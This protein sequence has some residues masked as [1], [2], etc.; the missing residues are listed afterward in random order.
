MENFDTAV[1]ATETALNSAGSAERENARYMES[2]E[3]HIQ[4]V[5]K[6]FSD[7]VLGDGGL[8]DLA[9][10]LLDAGTAILNFLNTPLGDL[11]VKI[12]LLVVAMTAL[13]AVIN[14]AFIAGL[15]ATAT[16]LVTT[17]ANCGGF[18]GTL[19]NIVSA[20]V[21]T[22]T[23]TY[24]TS[25]ALGALS[26]TLAELGINP[27]VLGITALIA[28]IYGAVK[29]YKKWENGIKD[30]SDALKSME[31]EISTSTS[32]I[33]Q[34]E[35]KLQELEDSKV[36]LTNP[37]D[38]RNLELEERSLERQ[39]AL[40]KQLLETKQ[41]EA[42]AE[43]E[44]M[45]KKTG[46]GTSA[47][48]T[49]KG[50][51]S[52]EE[53]GTVTVG[54]TAEEQLTKQIEGLKQLNGQIVLTNASLDS[55]KARLDALGV[56]E[57]E[58]T[59]TETQLREGRFANNEQVIQ[60]ILNYQN[61]LATLEGLNNTYNEVNGSAAENAQVL[62]QAAEAGVDNADSLNNL[63]D[64]YID[65]TDTAD[66]AS[67]A[68]E[69]TGEASEDQISAVEKLA[70]KYNVATDAIWDL[71][72]ANEQYASGEIDFTTALGEAEAQLE[73]NTQETQS[74]ADAYKEMLSDLENI[75]KAYETLSAAVEDYNA[76]GVM[77]M[78]NAMA[79]LQ[80]EPE[81]LALLQAE[82]G[83]LR[84]NKSA[85]DALIDA[86]IDEAQATLLAKTEEQAWAIVVADSANTTA[87]AGNA[88]ATAAGKTVTAA[89]DINAAGNTMLTA[90]EKF[91]EA[92][93]AITNGGGMYS[94]L[95]SD[96]TNALLELK[97]SAKS[98]YMALEQTRAGLHHV[99][100][101]ATSAGN[102][103][104]RAA[105]K[106]GSAIKSTT[107]LVREY[108]IKQMD[109]YI[110]KIEAKIAK[111]EKKLDKWEA[112]LEKVQDKYEKLIE[113]NQGWLD[114]LTSN[115]DI[116]ERF[117]STG[118]DALDEL[119]KKLKKK[120]KEYDD[121]VNKI[122]EEIDARKELIEGID[123]EID[124]I[125][126]RQKSIKEYYD[127]QIDALEKANEELEKQIKLE[128]LLDALNKAKSTKVKT[129]V[130]G[131]GFVYTT[132]SEKVSQATKNLQEYQ[133]SEKQKEEKTN[134]EKQRDAEIE[135]L[136]VQKNALE[137]QK[138][139]YELQNKLAEK[140][141]TQLEKEFD[142]QKKLLDY[143][144]QLLYE[145]IYD[146][147][148][149]F[150]NT[151]TE[152]TNKIN[153]KIKKI[154]D[155]IDVQNVKLDTANN[156][157]TK[158]KEKT[159]KQLDGLT[160]QQKQQGDN[161]ISKLVTIIEKMGA[162]KEQEQRTATDKITNYSGKKE[163][164]EKVTW[165]QEKA[166]YDWAAQN[167]PTATEIENM[168]NVYLNGT[169][170]SSTK[171]EST[172][173]SKVATTTTKTKTTTT[174]SKS[175]GTAKS[176][177]KAKGDRY[178]DEDG[179]YLLGDNPNQNELAIG[180]R[181]NGAVGINLSKGSG[182]VP[183]TLTSAL[184]D[185]AEEYKRGNSNAVLNGNTNNNNSTS[186]SI[187]NI[188]LPNVENGESFVDY[189]QNFSLDMT[190]AAYSRV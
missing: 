25:G 48:N 137:Q 1:N 5:R 148:D 156:Q 16:T 110:D 165:E 26:A 177:K 138:K 109:K 168:I 35:N 113:R 22:A 133:R 127:E 44:K 158:Y 155:K 80:L 13:N 15:Q 182:V 7:L 136:E 6:A 149:Q 8:T 46:T 174:G 86:K 47:G 49:W 160:K 57:Q 163:T 126:K 169:S 66:D 162:K 170:S 181:L 166:K 78:E 151:L 65:V 95:S 94:G 124:A 103:A 21:V 115:F 50:Y 85:L 97:N 30:A 75:S 161:I 128:E 27:V 81:Y 100:T 116:V 60:D 188:S 87:S 105:K 117:V 153:A 11:T 34:L 12:G 99:G 55:Y 73:A 74:A 175:S 36:D 63:V 125:E 179:F 146:Q 132:D 45:L 114:T 172:G 159:E 31:D 89:N 77:T 39:I 152:K 106:T 82:D 14:S 150:K 111:L 19:E 190:Q 183:H 88:T 37:E 121:N 143:D 135:T 79:L 23:Q 61:E 83:Q 38:I 52:K 53:F 101:A 123:E 147:T 119:L 134:L 141:L 184:M 9:K 186:I 24:A 112:K 67:D 2:L 56:T 164:T 104:S 58:L 40:E 176:P 187:G 108:V 171:K 70:K 10:G 122:N 43:A 54:G 32:K 41:A 20:L 120:K 69:N 98:S 107:D 157:L 62:T 189:L 3:A 129:Y 91:A 33:E 76:D 42:K 4:S 96:A 173:S 178:L 17:I 59:Q 180:S 90:A 167:Q 84:I 185:M 102:K 131:Q 68:V 92:W 130:E 51:G 118:N 142:A 29:A 72:N 145:K 140:Q 28:V 71:I 144:A 93:N 154:Q 139:D 18:V 64:A